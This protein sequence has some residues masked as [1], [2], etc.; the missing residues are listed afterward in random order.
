MTPTIYK[1]IFLE[2]SV[3]NQLIVLCWFFTLKFHLKIHNQIEYLSKCKYQANCNIIYY[4]WK[5]FVLIHI[6]L[7]CETSN[8]HQRDLEKLIILI[9]FN[10][11]IYLH[12]IKVWF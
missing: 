6:F 5:Y 12:S 10:L 4:L 1:S 7:L 8:H 3:Q 2:L 9:N 11:Y